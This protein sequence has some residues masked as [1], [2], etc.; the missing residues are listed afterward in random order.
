MKRYGCHD[1]APYAPIVIVRPAR[2]DD[3]EISYPHRMAKDC[4]FTKTDL[5]RSDSRCDG[6]KW[7]AAE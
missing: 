2:G 5:G 6:C 1:R 4:Q 7:R 3:P